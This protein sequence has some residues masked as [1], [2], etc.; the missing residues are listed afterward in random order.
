MSLV[1]T[2]VVVSGVAAVVTA[3]IMSWRSVFE[4]RRLVLGTFVA[5]LYALDAAADEILFRAASAR[6]CVASG[7][8][9]IRAAG[10]RCRPTTAV[11][12]IRC[13]SDG[14][15]GVSRQSVPSRPEQSCREADP[16]QI[17]VVRAEMQALLRQLTDVVEELP[18]YLSIVA[19]L[20]AAVRRSNER[21]EGCTAAALLRRLRKLRRSIRRSA[22]T[23]RRETAT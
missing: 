2:L 21:L 16:E 11:Q 5:K 12:L 19:P 3:L 13:S 23:L 14:R 8:Y 18:P 20:R 22:A 6:T 9:S 15:V 7:A 1:C 4:M 10:T 17:G